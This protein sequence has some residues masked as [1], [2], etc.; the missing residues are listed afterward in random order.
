MAIKSI[1]IDNR[2]SKINELLVHYS[3]GNFTKKIAPSKNFDEIDAIMYALNMLGEE[4]E[5]TT[6]SKNYFMQIFDSIK[7]MIF[8]LDKNGVIINLNKSVE[9]KLGWS[10]QEIIS[11]NIFDLLNNTNLFKPKLNKESFKKIALQQNI[12]FDVI[13]K[14]KQQLYCICQIQEFAVK[15]FI[16]S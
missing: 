1:K 15:I 5:T 3:H 10:K 16:Y 14:N 13:C 12:F 7:E 11:K 2:V 4:M 8:E 6:I 9:R